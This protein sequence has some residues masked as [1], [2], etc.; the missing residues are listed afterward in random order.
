MNPIL[1]LTGGAIFILGLFDNKKPVIEPI[2]ETPVEPATPPSTPE[3]V[4][5]T[6]PTIKTEVTE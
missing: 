5:P 2:T 3:S 6:T 4:E 1:L